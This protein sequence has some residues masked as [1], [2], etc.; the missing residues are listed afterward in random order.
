MLY[1]Y[2]CTGQKR[3]SII[4]T[5]SSLPRAQ[6]EVTFNC[7]ELEEAYAVNS[8]AKQ[9]KLRIYFSYAFVQFTCARLKVTHAH[10]NILLCSSVRIWASTSHA[11]AVHVG[12]GLIKV[13]TTVLVVFDLD[14]FRYTLT[15]VRVKST[16]FGKLQLQPFRLF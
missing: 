1:A 8:I 12:L 9:L 3:L 2:T 7:V 6:S 13:S 16:V 10:C 4:G 14:P 11:S 5:S 15:H